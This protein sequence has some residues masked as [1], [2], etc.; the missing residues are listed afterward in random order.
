MEIDLDSIGLG[1]SYFNDKSIF[2]VFQQ[3]IN[4]N[5][6]YMKI[7]KLNFSKNIQ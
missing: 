4:L 6:D 5:L 1:L 2:K 3:E 7:K